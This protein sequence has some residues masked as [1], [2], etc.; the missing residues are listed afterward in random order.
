MRNT[1]EVRAGRRRRGEIKT[2][3]KQN[4]SSIPFFFFTCFFFYLVSFWVS[5]FVL[6]MLSLSLF[7]SCFIYLSYSW[8]FFFSEHRI[9]HSKTATHLLVVSCSSCIIIHR[10]LHMQ[11]DTWIT[12]KAFLIAYHIDKK[13]IYLLYITLYKVIERQIILKWTTYQ[14]NLTIERNFLFHC[15]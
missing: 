8:K 15:F 14:N 9:V 11:M 13:Y 5:R 4:D 10:S 12:I 2:F 3:I 6:F 7:R 1:C